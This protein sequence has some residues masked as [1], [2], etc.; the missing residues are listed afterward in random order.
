MCKSARRRGKSFTTDDA[1]RGGESLRK[2]GGAATME[3]QEKRRTKQKV[4]TT[5][6]KGDKPAP[7]HR[8]ARRPV[9]QRCTRALVGPARL[10]EGHCSPAAAP[11]AAPPYASP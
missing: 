10:V 5:G 9:E 3:L 6:S 4:R 11:L 8:P 2:S 1:S 7:E